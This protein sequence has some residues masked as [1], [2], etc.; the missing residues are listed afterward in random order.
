MATGQSLVNLRRTIVVHTKLAGH[1]VRVEAARSR[2]HGLQILTMGRVAARL[3][4]GFIQPIDHEV[5]E[6]A[7]KAALGSTHLAELE[8]IKH[9]LAWFAPR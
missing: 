9:C 6:D 1:V 8:G 3:A 5:L 7:V 2:A 4:G